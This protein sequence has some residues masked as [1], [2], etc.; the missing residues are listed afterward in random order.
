MLYVFGEESSSGHFPVGFFGEDDVTIF[1][2]FVV[3]FVGVLD[4]GWV[5]RHVF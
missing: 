1:V 2:V 4:L 3:V 5:V